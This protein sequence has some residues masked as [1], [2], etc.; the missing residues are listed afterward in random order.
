MLESRGVPLALNQVQYSLLSAERETG[1]ADVCKE[2]GVRLVA[3]S[4]LCLGILAGQYRNSNGETRLPSNFLRSLL[5]SSLLADKGT[6]ELLGLLA[7]IGKQR[8]K[9]M[10]Q[11]SLNFAITESGGCAIVGARTAAQ[12]EENLGACGW[13]LDDGEVRALAAA[14]RRAPKTQKN[15]FFSD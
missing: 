7:E 3:Y 12:A 14:A 5:F 11:V 4:P 6:Q 9:T 13:S 10:A 8:G 1:I 2:L 15:A